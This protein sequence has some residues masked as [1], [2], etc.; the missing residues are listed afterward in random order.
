[1]P[2]WLLAIG[3]VGCGHV[4]F[5]PVAD[6]D[7]GASNDV[8]PAPRWGL[9]QTVGSGNATVTLKPVSPGHLIVVAMEID[10]GGSP[11]AV[12]DN[13]NSYVAVPTATATSSVLQVDLQIF[14]AYATQPCQVDTIRV[15]ANRDVCALVAW[16]VSG[17]TAS[18][19]VD[20]VAVLNDQPRSNAPLAPKI[21][22]SADGEFVVASAIVFDTVSGIHP[23][24]EFTNDQVSDGNGWAHLADPMAPAGVH[25]AQWDA[26]LGSYCAS[27]VAF[28]VGP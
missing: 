12:T 8:P 16:E 7:A 4:G 22:T 17:I 13:C 19:P 14:Y 9:V 1:V 21:T 5:D 2:R 15:A 6:Q 27:A 24:N 10:S 18:D 11:P 25:Q 3:L 26:T 20:A 28:K 23:G